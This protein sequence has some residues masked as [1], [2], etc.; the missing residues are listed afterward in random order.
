M[1]NRRAS[2][3]E[4]PCLAAVL[5]PRARARAAVLAHPRA[6]RHRARSSAKVDKAALLSEAVARLTHLTQRCHALE[7]EL[8]ELKGN[9]PPA[10]LPP[11]PPEPPDDDPMPGGAVAA[12]TAAAAATVV[13]APVPMAE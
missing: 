6:S 3:R 9:P 4:P 5:P 1:L 11:M 7:T 12:A 13:A 2:P 8:A 10:P